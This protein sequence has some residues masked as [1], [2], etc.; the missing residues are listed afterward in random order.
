[1]HDYHEE[2]FNDAWKGVLSRDGV[3]WLE[4]A[5]GQYT[6]LEYFYKEA[7]ASIPGQMSSRLL[8]TP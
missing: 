6:A 3:E 4:D 8:A 5:L 2:T 7:D 1:M